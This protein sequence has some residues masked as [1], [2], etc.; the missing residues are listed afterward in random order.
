MRALFSFMRRA[1]LVGC[2]ALASVSA[3]PYAAAADELRLS[4]E[5]ARAA[6]ARLLR[7]G[8]AAE[9]LALADGVLI[10]APGDV[11]ALLLKARAEQELGKH[12]DARKSAKL[13]WN[14]AEI[15]RDRFFAAMVQAG[16]LAS[17][18]NKGIA[19][20]WLRRAAQVAPETR[21]RNMAVS[22][23][24]KLRRLTPWRLN[25]ALIAAPSDNLNGG[26]TE[27]S[28]G[29]LFKLNAGSPPLSG[30]RY[31]AS[32]D[33]SYRH[34]LTENKRLKFGFALDSYRAELS[35]D[36]REEDPSARNND[37]RQDNFGLSLA[38]E[39]RAPDGQWLAN[40]VF[41]V[42]HSQRKGESFSN[43]AGL[44]LTFGRALGQNYTAAARGSLR[45]ERLVNPDRDDLM[46][47]E[48][49]LT[50]SRRFEF[51]KISLDGSV[52]DTLTDLHGIGK[53]FRAAQFSIAKARP[54]HGLLPR[55]SLSYRV[56]NFDDAPFSNFDGTALAILRKDKRHDQELAV[57][58]DVLLP[59]WDFYGFA[60]EVGVTY[61][62]RDS[63][64]RTFDAETTDL[65][66]GI[67]SVF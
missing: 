61:R 24:R 6:A 43:Q 60:P 56:S 30:F 11:Q 23:F 46:T 35:K 62:N 50:L 21:M 31:G 32:V 22:D 25:L 5:E 44:A 53:Q 48:L 28:Q 9:A 36:A 14:E 57:S 45:Y 40:A 41:D 65:R 58:V 4:L 42:K 26:S 49:G 16:T 59:K 52:G 29:V 12:K 33:F 7:A 8:R 2:L 27:G 37:F 3:S 54:I 55:L 19:Q 1:M 66:L 34:A 63:N 13:A 67:K 51:G 17:D 38:Y 10:G 18:G 20:Y 15:D 47:R 64:Y 39:L